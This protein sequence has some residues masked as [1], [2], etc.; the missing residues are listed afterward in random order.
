MATERQRQAARR[1]VKKAATAEKEKTISHMPK[2]T[3]TA[4]HM[5]KETRTAPGRRGAAVA[6]RTGGAHPKTRQARYDDVRRREIPAHSKMG[7]DE[8]DRALQKR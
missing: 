5:P 1:N 4:S 8:L 3:R 6:Q 2:E 7:R